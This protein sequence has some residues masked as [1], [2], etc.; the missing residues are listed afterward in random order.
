M[1]YGYLQAAQKLNTD[2]L[3]VQLALA[4]YWLAPTRRDLSKAVAYL[5]KAVEYE[6]RM[7]PK[8][9]LYLRGCG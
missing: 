3:N 8:L 4:E 7:I 1:V 5:Q 2:R 6:T 9:S